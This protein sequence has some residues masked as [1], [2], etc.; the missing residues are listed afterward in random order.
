MNSPPNKIVRI[1]YAIAFLGAFVMRHINASADESNLKIIE[2]NARTG[3]PD[4]EKPLCTAIAERA[5][6]Q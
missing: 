4:N 5:R 6:S 1:Q 3:C 2:K